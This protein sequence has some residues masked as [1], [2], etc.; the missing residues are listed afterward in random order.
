MIVVAFLCEGTTFLCAWSLQRLLLRT[1]EWIQVA[2]PQLAGN[3]ASNILPAGSAV[4]SLLQI[5]LLTRHGIDLTRAIVSLAFA[6]MLTVLAGLVLFPT[7]ALMP[8][9][10]ADVNPRNGVPLAILFLSLCAPMFV[11]ALRSD[12][13]MRWLAK[14][15]ERTVQRISW[16]HA[17]DDLADRIIK[18]R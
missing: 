6:G 4:G 12:R 10:T 16:L 2:V 1:R 5:R 7:I 8:L 15:C 17:H 9:G 18:E 3:A 14:N 11:V 13:P